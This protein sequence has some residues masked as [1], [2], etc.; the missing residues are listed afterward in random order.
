MA[1]M[2]DLKIE[3]IRQQHKRLN[4]CELDLALARH[5]TEHM[6]KQGMILCRDKDNVDF[7]YQQAAF[8]CALVVAYGRIFTKSNGQSGFAKSKAKYNKGESK[9]HD[10]LLKLR[11][12]LYA[13]SDG[14]LFHVRTIGRGINIRRVPQYLIRKDDL[15][16]LLT[17]IEKLSNL[18]I[19]RRWQ[20]QKML[21]EAE[22]L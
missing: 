21:A 19:A 5:H 9:L 6:L 20:L 10:E 22:K 4:I 18:I 12:M 1:G 14:S 3:K 17:M 13:H 7:Y 8:V 11:H 16:L 15:E 2:A